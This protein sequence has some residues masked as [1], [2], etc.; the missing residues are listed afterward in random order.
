[1]IVDNHST[2]DS[3]VD[4]ENSMYSCAESLPRSP[5]VKCTKPVSFFLLTL[6]SVYLC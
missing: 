3:T 5:E 1:M 6:V 4:D 2:A